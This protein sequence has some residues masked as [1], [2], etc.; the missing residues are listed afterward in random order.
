[1]VRPDEWD[2]FSQMLWHG[3]ANTDHYFIEQDEDQI[4]QDAKDTTEQQ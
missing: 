2:A 3:A 1:M 4:E